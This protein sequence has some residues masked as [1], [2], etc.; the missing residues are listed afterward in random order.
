MCVCVFTW[1]TDMHSAR[2]CHQTAIDRILFGF[3][4][5]FMAG[6]CHGH[7][8]PHHSWQWQLATGNSELCDGKVH[9]GVKDKNRL[10]SNLLISFISVLCWLSFMRCL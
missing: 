6:K 9:F 1:H 4:I 2:P 7:P 10:D 5:K 3:S 8:T